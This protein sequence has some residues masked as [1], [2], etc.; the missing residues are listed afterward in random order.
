MLGERGQWTAAPG[1]GTAAHVD[2]PTAMIVDIPSRT[3]LFYDGLENV[4]ERIK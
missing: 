3:F 4:F 2:Q 1:I